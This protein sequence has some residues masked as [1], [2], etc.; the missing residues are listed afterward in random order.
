M[1]NKMY[2]IKEFVLYSIL[3]YISEII[4]S[5]IMHKELESGFMYGPYTIV[6]GISIPFIYM[7][8]ENLEEKIKDKWKRLLIMFITGFIISFILEFIGAYLLKYI[9]HVEM[10]NYEKLPLHIGKFLS[11]EV[12]TFWTI[13]VMLLYKFVKPITDKITKHTP[14]FL[15]LGILLIMIIDF[16]LTTVKAFI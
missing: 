15:S 8:Y 7:V 5:A 14:K 13:G 11:I 2:Y 4:G 16:I 6:Y 1:V 3:G 10:W 9:Y 12:T